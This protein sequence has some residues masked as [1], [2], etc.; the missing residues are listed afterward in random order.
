MR[1]WSASLF[2]HM[3]RSGILMTWLTCWVRCR[4]LRFYVIMINTILFTLTFIMS[5]VLVLVMNLVSFCRRWGFAYKPHGVK[6][7]WLSSIYIYM[8]DTK[9]C[10]SVCIWVSGFQM[11]LTSEY[12]KNI[13][14]YDALFWSFCFWTIS[15]SAVLIST[16]VN[17]SACMK[18][19]FLR[20]WPVPLFLLHRYQKYY[21]SSF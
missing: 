4:F 15:K 20:T 21:P 11:C 9:R 18:V 10:R 19:S 5:G 3:L 7:C 17:H 2:S 6:P 12:G 13:L 14:Q 16:I 8:H 1:S